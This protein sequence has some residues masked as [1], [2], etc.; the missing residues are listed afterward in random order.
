MFVTTTADKVPFGAITVFHTVNLVEYTVAAVAAWN[1]ARIT[2]NEL[3]KLSDH[4]LSDIGLT[5][6]DIA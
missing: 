5:R 4:Q 2:R 1:V 6:G 3:H